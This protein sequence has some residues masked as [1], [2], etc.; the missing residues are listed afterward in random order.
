MQRNILIIIG[1]PD[2]APGRYLRALAE[3]YAC[4]ARASHHAVRVVDVAQLAFPLL[5]SQQEWRSGGIPEALRAAHADLM[6]ADHLLLCYPLW[7]G[8]VPALFKGFLEQ[9]LR[10]DLSADGKSTGAKPLA[11]KSA[12]V[13]V[14]MGMP[15]WVYRWFYGAHSLRSLERNVL[16][17]VGAGPVRDTLIGM[18][19]TMKPAQRTRWLKRVEALGRAAA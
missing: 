1:H 2:P 10:I 8:D 9:V 15:G 5:R 13:L 7:L 16:R 4:G 18:V 6:W 17:F 12:R 19:E 3:A 14:T 11:G